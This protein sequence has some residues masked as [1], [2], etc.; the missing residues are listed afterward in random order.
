VDSPFRVPL[1]EAKGLCGFVLA[2]TFATLDTD[3]LGFEVVFVIKAEPTLLIPNR[4]ALVHTVIPSLEALDSTLRCAPES[5]GKLLLNLLPFH[6]LV[7]PSVDDIVTLF[8]RILLVNMTAF[9]SFRGWAWVTV[10]AW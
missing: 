4:Y 9:A 10:H 6:L 8:C 1:G 5:R 7:V 3:M 2:V